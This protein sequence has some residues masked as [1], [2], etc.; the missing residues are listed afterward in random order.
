MRIAI[1][2]QTTFGAGGAYA[3]VTQVVA[4]VLRIQSQWIPPSA[5][6]AKKKKR[7]YLISKKTESYSQTD[8]KIR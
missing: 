5:T 8:S 1:F 3:E 4:I 6:S 2:A 7:K